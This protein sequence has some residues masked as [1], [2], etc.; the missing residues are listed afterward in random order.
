MDF[1]FDDQENGRIF[2][3]VSS[4]CYLP[5]NSIILDE[6]KRFQNTEKPFKVA[7]SFSGVFLDQCKRYNPEVLNSFVRLVDTGMVEV[8]EQTYYHSLSSLYE[9]KKSSLSR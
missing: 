8:M 4:K 1:Y 6:I 9:D 2:N 3:R 7:Y 5:T